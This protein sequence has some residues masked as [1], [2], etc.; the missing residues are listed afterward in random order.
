MGKRGGGG[1]GMAELEGTVQADPSLAAPGP[2]RCRQT[3]RR[4]AAPRWP[5]NLRSTGGGGR[6]GGVQGTRPDI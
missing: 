3:D 4:S 6:G 2:E 1:G 5:T